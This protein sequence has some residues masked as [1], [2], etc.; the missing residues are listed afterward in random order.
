MAK[1]KRWMANIYG[2]IKQRWVA[3]FEKVAKWVK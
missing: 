1:L 2:W 3:K